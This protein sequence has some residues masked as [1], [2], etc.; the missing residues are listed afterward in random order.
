MVPLVATPPELP[1]GEALRP[2]DLSQA[3]PASDGSHLRHRAAGTDTQLL[4]LQGAEPGR[5]LAALVPLDAD[6]LDRLHEVE[7]LW[8][9]LAGR[10]V[11]R[12]PRLTP[13]QR[14]KLRLMLQAVDGRAQKASHREIAEVLFG[15]ARVTDHPWKSSPWRA[16]VSR[17]LRDGRAMIAGGYRRLLRQRRRA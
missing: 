6:A 4:I 15:P 16:R 3:V 2:L 10:A 13:Q 12:D 9:V 5:P 11:Q 8:R 7:R 14:R 17:L 1:L